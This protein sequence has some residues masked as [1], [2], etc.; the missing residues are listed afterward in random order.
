MFLV[1]YACTL[2]SYIT[3][4]NTWTDL[5]LQHREVVV[6]VHATSSSLA[7]SSSELLCVCPLETRHLRSQNSGIQSP[8]ASFRTIYADAATWPAPAISLV[9]PET[10]KVRWKISITKTES[11]QKIASFLIANGSAHAYD[12]AELAVA[13][14]LRSAVEAL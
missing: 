10:R 11:R 14:R 6:V 8:N 5:L 4:P 3:Y 13:K 12:C 2:R 9:N 7:S 1:Y